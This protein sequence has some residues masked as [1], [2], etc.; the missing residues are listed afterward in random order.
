MLEAVSLSTILGAIIRTY[1]RRGWTLRV[2]LWCQPGC[3]PPVVW[4]R[5]SR[6]SDHVAR[7]L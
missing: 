6:G 2:V 3:L 1:P 5:V 4:W 7:P